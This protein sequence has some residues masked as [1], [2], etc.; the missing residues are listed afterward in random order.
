MPLRG[1]Q[2]RRTPPACPHQRNERQTV[3]ISGSGRPRPCAKPQG[4]L[5]YT[6]QSSSPSQTPP[7]TVGFSDKCS[8]PCLPTLLLAK[9]TSLR[10]RFQDDPNPRT[11]LSPVELRRSED[12]ASSVRCR[13]LWNGKIYPRVF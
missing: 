6:R 9:Q 11:G 7:A 8:S 3:L 5:L 12:I 2:H 10:R 13:V 4:R 1:G